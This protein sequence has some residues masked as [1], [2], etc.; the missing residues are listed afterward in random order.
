MRVRRLPPVRSAF[1]AAL[2]L[3]LPTPALAEQALVLRCGTGVHDGETRGVVGLPSGGVFCPLFADPKQVRSFAT[4]LYGKFPRGTEGKNLGSVGIGDGVAL[5]RVNGPR[6]G[7]GLQVGFDAAVFSQF[8]LDAPSDALLNADYLFGIPLSW[9]IRSFS[10]R[11]RVYHQSSHLGD[12]TL[13]RLG[14][15]VTRENLSFESVELIL[16]QEL[17]PLRVYGGGEN[18]FH[19]S[20]ASLA[21]WVAHGGAELRLGPPRGARFV[22]AADV[23]SSEEQE[24]KPAWSL[25]GGVEIAWWRKPDHPPRLTSIVFEYYAGPSPYGQFFLEATRFIG[26]GFMFQL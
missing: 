14:S 7:E 23:K 24:W 10:A 16:S 20:P 11:L 25:K 4:Y 5:L 12:E 8:S 9:R 1:W 22:A 26:G 13:L 15:E 3:S 21:R 2:V 6:P 17:G 18:L 19:K